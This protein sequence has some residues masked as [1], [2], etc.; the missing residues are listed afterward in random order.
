MNIK[1]IS[2]DGDE[3]VSTDEAAQYLRLVDGDDTGVVAGLIV[4]A[5][6]MA[7]TWNG[8]QMTR[9]QWDLGLDCWPGTAPLDGTMMPNPYFGFWPSDAYRMLSSAWGQGMI[10]LLAPLI[11]VESVTSKSSTGV[12]TTLA[13]NVDYVV[14]TWKEP[15]IICPMAN[16]NWPAG[17]LWPSS[18]IHIQFTAGYLPADVPQHIKLGMSLLVTQWFEDRVPFSAIRFVAEPP[19]NVTNLFTHDKLWRF[20]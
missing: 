12:V 19:F 6:L 3:P 18:P 14:D 16:A 17:S 7:E 11:S 13:E 20:R 2:D 10:P 8:R 9:K 5:R 15:G 1:L 4:A